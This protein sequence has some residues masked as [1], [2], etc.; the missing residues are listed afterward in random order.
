MD[1]TDYPLKNNKYFNNY[2]NL[3][4]KIIKN[5]NIEVIYTVY[6]QESSILYNFFDK[7]CFKE[8]KITKILVSHELKK[9]YEI[10]N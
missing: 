5:N 10:N 1:G 4:I 9:C 8:K 2:K 6:P 3:F 7:N